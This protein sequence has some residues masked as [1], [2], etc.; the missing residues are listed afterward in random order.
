M[1]LARRQKIVDGCMSDSGGVEGDVINAL[2]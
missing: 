1:A 2:L